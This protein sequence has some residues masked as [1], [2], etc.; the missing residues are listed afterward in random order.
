MSA[1]FVVLS[2]ATALAVAG[3]AGLLWLRR[4]WLVVDVIGESMA[5]A[6][7]DGDRVLVRRGRAEALRVGDVIVFGGPLH[8]DDR[9]PPGSVRPAMVVKRVAALPGDPMPDAV[10][11]Q[12]G[13]TTVPSASMVLLGDNA[14]QSVD[15]RVWGPVRVDGVRGLVVRRIAP[16]PGREEHGVPARS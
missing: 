1:T 9:P 3:G 12:D 2:G 11:A 14:D 5:P 16:R 8:D 4:T 6:F 7:R 10:A 15:S 13:G